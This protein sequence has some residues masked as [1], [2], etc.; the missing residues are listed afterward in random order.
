MIDR[1]SNG[2]QVKTVGG[3]VIA[4]NGAWRSFTMVAAPTFGKQAP[5]TGTTGLGS[6]VTLQWTTVPDEGYWVC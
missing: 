4:D 1:E 3:G 2:W 6:P 5:V